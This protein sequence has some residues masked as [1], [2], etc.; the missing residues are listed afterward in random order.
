MR[1]YHPDTGHELDPKW[2]RHRR[3][4]PSRFIFSLRGHIYVEGQTAEGDPLLGSTLQEGKRRV[5]DSLKR[6]VEWQT[7][8][9]LSALVGQA[10]R[11]RF[12][13]SDADIFALQFQN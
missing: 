9:D 5:G 13:M 8:S 7:T 4:R 11:L 1:G 2:S 10:V 12:V 3:P 6:S